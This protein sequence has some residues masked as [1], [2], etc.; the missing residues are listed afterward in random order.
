[1]SITLSEL[2]AKKPGKGRKSRPSAFVENKPPEDDKK[3]KLVRAKV[4][5][6]KRNIIDIDLTKPKEEVL[7][8]ESKPRPSVAILSTGPTEKKETEDLSNKTT[9]K[10]ATRIDITPTDPLFNINAP[11]QPKP[12]ITTFRESPKQLFEKYLSS[13]NSVANYNRSRLL[14]E[15]QAIVGADDFNSILASQAM[16]N[17]EP[18]NIENLDKYSEYVNNTRNDIIIVSPIDLAFA[19]YIKQKE[20]SFR[21]NRNIVISEEVPIIEGI[22]NSLNI[23][24]LTMKN[25]TPLNY[26]QSDQFRADSLNC[27]L[28]YFNA[29]FCMPQLYLFLF[30]ALSALNSSKNNIRGNKYIL[31]QSLKNFGDDV[32]LKDLLSRIPKDNFYEIILDN[33][34]AYTPDTLDTVYSQLTNTEL[35]GGFVETRLNK[36]NK[37]TDFTDTDLSVNSIDGNTRIEFDGK[38]YKPLYSKNA[39]DQS[40]VAV[41]KNIVHLDGSVDDSLVICSRIAISSKDSGITLVGKLISIDEANKVLNIEK[42]I[43]GPYINEVPDKN[44]NGDG[45]YRIPITQAFVCEVVKVDT[46]SSSTGLSTSITPPPSTAPPSTAPPTT[47]PPTTTPPTIPPGAPSPSG[48]GK[49]KPTTPDPTATSTTASSST[50]T[51][52]ATTIP[53]TTTPATTTPATTTPEPSTVVDTTNIADELLGVQEITQE[54]NQKVSDLLAIIRQLLNYT[55]FKKVS[56]LV[57][58]AGGTLYSYAIEL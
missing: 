42:L 52:P 3:E 38:T 14:N 29:R 17:I 20:S 33:S 25:F 35:S 22:I 50:T 9:D 6:Q 19:Y 10:K 23:K 54:Q 43:D 7:N 31:L 56:S 34:Y 40:K 37:I 18:Q 48:K 30:H 45:T 36:R 51:T 8:V 16:D 13:L 39:K 15:L 41:S 27:D 24:N 49:K 57:L 53:A 5:E 12:N 21:S 55:S 4:I 1:M 58:P 44:D 47:A 11:Q 32:K 28:V 26:V 2:I 46:G